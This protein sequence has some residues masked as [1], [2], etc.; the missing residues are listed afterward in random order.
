MI[1]VDGGDTRT[2]RAS[3]DELKQQIDRISQE[4]Y[5]AGKELAEHAQTFNDFIEQQRKNR[6]K[7][8]TKTLKSH[9]LISVDCFSCYSHVSWISVMHLYF[10][11]HATLC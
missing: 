11:T 6:S 10:F 1:D 7:V 2:L 5:V 9:Y 8:V 3:A 4:H